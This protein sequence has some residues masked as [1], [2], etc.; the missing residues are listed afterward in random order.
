MNEPDFVLVGPTINRLHRANYWHLLL[1]QS[2]QAVSVFETVIFQQDCTH[3]Q[4]S[5]QLHD[6]VLQTD[7]LLLRASSGAVSCKDVPVL[8]KKIYTHLLG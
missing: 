8:P 7:A 5:S 1:S 4:V 6:S 2:L 3:F